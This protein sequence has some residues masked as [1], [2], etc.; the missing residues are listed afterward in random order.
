M[1]VLFVLKKYKIQFGSDLLIFR[2]AE[3]YLI[4][5]EAGN[6]GRLNELLSV[7]NSTLNFKEE[8]PL[9]MSY[10]WTR[11]QDLKLEGT[12]DYVLPYPRRAVDSDPL[13]K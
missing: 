5:A 11:W 3:M 6:L 1:R 8:R 9:E 10:E 7:R 2:I 13:L 4:S 12:E